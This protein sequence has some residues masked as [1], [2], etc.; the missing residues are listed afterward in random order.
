MTTNLSSLLDSSPDRRN[1]PKIAGTGITVHRVASWYKLGHSAEEI[2][3][4]YPH[5]TL[6]GVYAALAYYHANREE[7]DA[8]IMAD[9]LEAHR[10]EQ[11]YLQKQQVFQ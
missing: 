7:I 8:E 6:A 1:R 10:L 11:E 4:Q 2:T 9:D 3:R 5:L